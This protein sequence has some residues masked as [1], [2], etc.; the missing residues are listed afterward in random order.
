MS[1]KAWKPKN[2]NSFPKKFEIEFQLVLTCWNQFSFVNISPTLV[3]DT[4]MEKSSR[5]LQHGNPK[6]CEFHEIKVAKARKSSSEWRHF[7]KLYV[8]SGS[9]SVHFR[10]SLSTMEATSL[11]LSC[12]KLNLLLIFLLLYF[13]EDRDVYLIFKA[14]NKSNTGSLSLDEFYQ[15]YTACN[16]KW[17][18]TEPEAPWFSHLPFPGPRIGTFIRK[19]V[20]SPVFEG[21]VCKYG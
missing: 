7:P 3:I 4:S 19:I 18:P 9:I 15:V 13:T 16:L 6:K 8:Y 17:R 1:T 5:V 11:Y 14:L 21:F 12:T 2:F 20:I 10:C